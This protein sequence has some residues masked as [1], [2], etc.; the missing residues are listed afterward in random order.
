MKRN[1]KVVARVSKKEYV[2]MI[3]NAEILGMT[4]SGYIRYRCINLTRV[5]YK[6]KKWEY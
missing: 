1:K 5:N 6:A 4:I 2:V 3:K